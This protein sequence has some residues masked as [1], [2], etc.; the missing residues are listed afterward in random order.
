MLLIDQEASSINF[1]DNLKIITNEIY[2]KLLYWLTHLD[3]GTLS[4]YLE[5][6]RRYIE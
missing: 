1:N 6:L 2:R 3:I 4:R 5:L